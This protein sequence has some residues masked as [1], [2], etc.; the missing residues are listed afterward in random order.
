MK[1][2]CLS[3]CRRYRYSLTRS[4]APERGRVCWIMLNPST[5]DADI[6]DPTIRR[7][8]GFTESFGKGELVV[9]NLCAY[10]ATQPRDLL[11][12]I[13]EGVDPVGC[14]NG[15]HMARAVH[16]AGLV[17]AAWGSIQKSLL[18]WSQ[19][20]LKEMARDA[21]QL[22]SLGYNGDGSPPHPLY[23]PKNRQLVKWPEEKRG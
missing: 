6:D 22:W 7:C 8:I 11:E 18:R 3:D 15:L 17:V 10:R 21:I 19:V 20:V 13:S 4:W 1:A 2:A 9:V 12:A 5:A 23:V 14:D 16:G